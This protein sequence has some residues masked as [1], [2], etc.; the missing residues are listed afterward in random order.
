MPTFDDIAR[1]YWRTDV[2]TSGRQIYSCL[3]NDPAKPSNDDPLIGVLESSTL[4]EEVV[5]THNDA[6]T[7]FGRRYRRALQE[8][9]PTAP[10]P[11]Q[12]EFALELQPDERRDVLEF[13]TWLRHGFPTLGLKASTMRGLSKIFHT[14]GGND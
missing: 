8:P 5:H 4:A 6:L 7:R 10:V 13:M 9:L 14:L 12:S 11:V 2:K 3:S 1:S